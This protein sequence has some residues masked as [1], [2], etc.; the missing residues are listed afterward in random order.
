MNEISTQVKNQIL[1]EVQS[2]LEVKQK[3]TNIYTNTKDK[4]KEFNDLRDNNSFYDLISYNL[5]YTDEDF[6]NKI[7]SNCWRRLLQNKEIKEILPKTHFEKLINQN[8]FPDFNINIVISTLNKFYQDKDKYII[9][10]II[11]CFEILD[12][13]NY[14]TNSTYAFK[15]KSILN[16]A[17]YRD[18]TGFRR[19]YNTCSYYLN[20]LIALENLFARIDSL[21]VKQ[22]ESIKVLYNFQKYVSQTV[23]LKYFRVLFKESLC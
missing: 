13:K 17:S 11:Y 18:Y 3:L 8:E 2:L 4:L 20:A 10:N 9:E 5:Y 23:E 15:D 19:S 6:N 1:A 16:L 14:K 22:Q 12:K 21:E 7:N